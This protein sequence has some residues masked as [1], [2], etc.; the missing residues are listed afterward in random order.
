M[1]TE[2]SKYSSNSRVHRS[3]SARMAAQGNHD[4]LTLSCLFLPLT[5]LYLLHHKESRTEP[6]ISETQKMQGTTLF[7]IFSSII[8]IF[9]NSF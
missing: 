1:V 5:S 7:S 2:Y 3:H 6:T 4:L 9:S 8:Y